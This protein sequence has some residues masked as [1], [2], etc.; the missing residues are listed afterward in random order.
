MKTKSTLKHKEKNLIVLIFDE[1]QGKT[2]QKPFD[3][4]RLPAGVQAVYS[5]EGKWWV[6]VDTKGGLLCCNIGESHHVYDCPYPIIGIYD[7]SISLHMITCK[8]DQRQF[9]TM[10]SDV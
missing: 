2:I 1:L 5:N 6:K 3:K 10:L 8:D 7:K 4:D 9:M